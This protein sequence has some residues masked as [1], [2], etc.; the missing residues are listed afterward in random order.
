M[1]SSSDTVSRRHPRSH[2]LLHSC[3]SS[4]NRLSVSLASRIL[5]VYSNLSSKVRAD[6]KGA[7]AQSTSATLGF[8]FVILAFGHTLAALVLSLGHA[9]F[10]MNQILR[11]HNTVADAQ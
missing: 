5:R 8:I 2:A 3:S 1:N 10:R 9:A 11:V 6:R 7:L 4:P